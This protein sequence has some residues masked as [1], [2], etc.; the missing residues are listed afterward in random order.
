M[1]EV[2]PW[3]WDEREEWLAGRRDAEETTVGWEW[4][5]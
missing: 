4:Q 3:G 1:V 2:L 5:Q